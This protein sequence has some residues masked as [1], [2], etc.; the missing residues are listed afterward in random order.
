MEHELFESISQRIR[1]TE[2]E[3]N[4]RI[5]EITHE[6]VRR[7][8]L[9]ESQLRESKTDVRHSDRERLVTEDFA[10]ECDTWVPINKVFHLGA[11]GPSGHENDTY[12]SEDV[13]Y[14]VNNLLN[15]NGSVIQHF[16]KILLHN[17]LFVETSYVFYGFTGFIGSSIMPIFKQPLIK[18]ATP[19]TMV[20]ISTYMAALG[21][22]STPETGRFTNDEFEVWDLFPRNV[23]KDSEGDIFVIDAEIK[24]IK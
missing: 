13:I 12:V 21:F 10:A 24:L 6:L 19:A 3:E 7:C 5:L 8:S 16:N 17:L 15:S 11:P 9:Y 14:K 20:E 18:N 2:N 23:L 4:F 1:G 22:R